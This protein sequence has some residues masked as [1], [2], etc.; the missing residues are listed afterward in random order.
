MGTRPDILFPLFAALDT[1]PGIGARTAKALA[2]LN[3]EV[4]RDFL[5][6]LPHSGISRQPV[7]SVTQVPLPATVTV[8]ITVRR[9]LPAASKGRPHRVEVE[10]AGT[11]FFLVFF[12]ARGDYLDTLLPAGQE[13]IVSGRVELYDGVAQMTHPDHVLRL[14]QANDLPEFEPVYPLTQ[15]VTQKTMAKAV[16]ASC[17]VRPRLRRGSTRRCR[18]SAN[19]PTGKMR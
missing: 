18:P 4:P 17:S 7:E 8:R 16:A 13:R 14:D 10:D 5:Y 11:R 15:G 19:G 9:H 1:L 12:H 6:T 3:I 2:G